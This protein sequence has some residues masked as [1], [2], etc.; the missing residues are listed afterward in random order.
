MKILFVGDYSNLHATLAAELR[1]KGHQ[2]TVLS[3]GCGHMKV[4][5]DIFVDRGPG[6]VGSVK[7]LYRLFSLLPELKGY[8]VVQF[9]NPHFFALRP[10]KLRY[11]LRELKRQ[12]GSLFLSL[13]G[14][15][16]YF[17][18]AC[19]QRDMFRFSEFRVGYEPTEFSHRCN[20][21]E[22]GYML[23][24]VATYSEDFYGALDG[25][26][27]VLPEYDMAARPV[28]GDRLAFTNLPIDLRSLSPAPFEISDKVNI[29]VGMRSGNELNKGT[30]R[31]LE[32]AKRVEKDMP[33]RVKVLN[34]KD[35]P[36]N[37]YLE[38]LRGAH[39]VLDQLYSYSPGMNALY[40]M[41]LGR[42]SGSG[43][44]PEY[45]DMIGEDELRPIFELS[46]LN[47]DLEGHIRELVADSDRLC[48]MAAEGRLLVERHNDS[49]LV[50]SRYEEHWKYILDHK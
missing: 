40:T 16:H 12:N 43:A 15:D 23:P 18:K 9:I 45:Y 36:F 41:A 25:A 50:A 6:F 44:Q 14:N 31:L 42:V 35:L 2:V 26:M 7:Y 46:P 19:L 17:V 27:S 32:I 5:S 39:L 8:D 21:H 28:L 20:N 49:R 33:E 29:L 47:T 11:F 30:E 3:D 38:A 13:A 34:I 4:A 1:R 48:T 24:S 10:G 22:R 37:E